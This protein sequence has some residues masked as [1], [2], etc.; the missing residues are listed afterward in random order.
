VAL[1]EH[2][3]KVD[4]IAALRGHRARAGKAPRMTP[5]PAARSG[6]RPA[7]VVARHLIVVQ[8]LEDSERTRHNGPL[9]D[10]GLLIPAAVGATYISRRAVCWPENV[11]RRRAAVVIRL[12]RVLVGC[13]GAAVND[14]I[15]ID[16]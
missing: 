11:G 5:P 3:H 13:K 4:T 9:S 14:L 1:V 8:E 16:S 6:A 2:D 7:D 10:T 15:G 12:A